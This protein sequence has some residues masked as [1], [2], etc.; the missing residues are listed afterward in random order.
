MICGGA[1]KIIR[2]STER[3]PLL[4]LLHLVHFYIFSPI[5]LSVS[6]AFINFSPHFRPSGK[7]KIKA[8]NERTTTATTTAAAFIGGIA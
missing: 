7:A 3:S 8:A 4:P 5:N 6:R 1:A 2:H